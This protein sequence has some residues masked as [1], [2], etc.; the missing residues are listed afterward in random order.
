VGSSFELI[1]IGDNFLNRILIAQALRSTV[2]K[3]DLMKLKSFYKI[4]NRGI[5]NG[6][7]AL[8]EM[9]KVFTR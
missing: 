4:L 5:F 7:E 3:G 1:G 6:R 2:D 8:K 9:F